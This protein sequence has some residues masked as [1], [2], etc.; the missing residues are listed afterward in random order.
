M[1][2]QKQ[3]KQ[4]P[5]ISLI[6]VNYN[7]CDFLPRMLKSATTQS[8][9][10]VEVIVVDCQSTDQSVNHVKSYFPTV[11]IIPV[12][13]E[14]FGAG[15]NYGVAAGRGTYIALFNADMYFSKHF[16]KDIFAS[17]QKKSVE[18][19]EKLVLGCKIIPFDTKN[20][21]VEPYWG[22]TFDLFGFPQTVSRSEDA[23]MI[24]G[25]PFFM[26]RSLY[27]KTKG[28]HPG[29]FLYGEDAE[30][31]W[32]LILHGFS[33]DIDNSIWIAHYG[34]AAIG[35]ELSPRKLAYVLFGTTAPLITN[36]HWITIII[37]A[38]IYLIS[39][40]FLCL[41]LI[42]YGKGN[43]SYLI[44]VLKLYAKIFSKYTVWKKYRAWAQTNRSLS[45]WDILQKLKI[46]PSV[47]TNILSRAS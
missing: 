12:P 24:N 27:I 8:Y 17:F 39:F 33:L 6:V 45:D 15:A 28:F 36:L 38:P 13:N 9:P 35:K 16:V 43:P 3:S 23:L 5:L 7:E 20:E 29:I 30:Y 37:L 14:G 19:G 44:A 11:R 46:L 26:K 41:V 34:S 32:R 31:C 4:Y 47:F 10:N 40:V 42:L 1:P 21:T 18:K 25:N 2:S 22:G